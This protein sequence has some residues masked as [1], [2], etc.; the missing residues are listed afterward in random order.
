LKTGLRVQQNLAFE[1]VNVYRY[2][3]AGIDEIRRELLSL[4]CL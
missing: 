3:E 4:A 2:A 1:W